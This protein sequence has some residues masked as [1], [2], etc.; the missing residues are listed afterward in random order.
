LPEINA[1]GADLSGNLGVV[2]DY[3]KESDMLKTVVIAAIVGGAL[4]SLPIPAMA[5]TRAETV[6][7]SA[8]SNMSG[9]I[10]RKETV[11]RIGTRARI[12][13]MPFCMGVQLNDFGNAAGLGKT[14]GANPVL[15]AALARNGFR[16]DEVTNIRINGNS[17]TLY[18]HRE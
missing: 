3:R 7:R 4:A 14:I 17:V 13:V 8:L 1:G 18:V 6:C 15:A 5:D 2:G 11:R 9:T 16:A 12:Y 10:V